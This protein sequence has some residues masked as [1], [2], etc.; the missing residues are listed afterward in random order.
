MIK[1][2]SLIFIMIL[3]S[4]GG[5][6]SDEQRKQMLEARKRQAITK[7]TDA[8]IMESAFS[9]GKQV[10]EGVG[11]DV[12]EKG[13]TELENKFKVKINWLEP[14]KGT[15]TK[16]E[17]Q[18]IDAYINGVTSGKIQFDNVQRIGNDSLLYTKADVVEKAD[19][20]IEVK[21]TWNVWISKKELI[22]A[23]IVK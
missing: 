5:K 18:L 2:F 13:L 12:D 7:V 23:M 3:V 20:S 6:V 15:A 22:L 11:Q 21:G 9:F 10:L 8:E 16:I 17:Q 4:C 14:G 1:K 19:G